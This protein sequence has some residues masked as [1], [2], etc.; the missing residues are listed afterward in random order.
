MLIT[1]V[2]PE[3]WKTETFPGGF[4]TWGDCL[5][6]SLENP[7]EGTALELMARTRLVFAVLPD[8]ATVVIL[9]QARALKPTYLNETS[10]L[11]L[12]IPNDLFNGGKRTYRFEGIDHKISGSSEGPIRQNLKCGEQLTIDGRV[13]VR[14]V[15]GGELELIR[16]GKRLVNLSHFPSQFSG[17]GGNLY[18]DAVCISHKHEQTFYERGELIF[19]IA[20]IM[21]IDSELPVIA[22]GSEATREIRIEGADDHHY[23]LSAKFLGEKTAERPPSQ[24]E[25]AEILGSKHT[26]D[27]E[28]PILIRWNK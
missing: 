15:Y 18:A 8:D 11:F 26:T 16:P 28:S 14:S 21:S 1:Q 10:G 3:W 17:E 13:G 4:L 12:N 22:G 25:G 6:T 9:Q 7:A 2:T 24:T 27:P 23:L 5:W 19:D 20:A